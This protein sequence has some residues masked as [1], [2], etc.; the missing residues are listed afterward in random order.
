MAG[1]DKAVRA[2]A[3]VA[4]FLRKDSQLRSPGGE[5]D[6]FKVFRRI[7]TKRGKIMLVSTASLKDEPL[8]ISPRV[9]R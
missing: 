7:D 2:E 5:V 4:I 1:K 8:A 9:P 3:L 6:P